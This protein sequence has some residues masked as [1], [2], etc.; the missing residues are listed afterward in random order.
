MAGLDGVGVSGGGK[1]QPAE[2][3][4]LLAATLPPSELGHAMWRRV[5][6]QAVR[7][8]SRWRSSRPPTVADL[9]GALHLPCLDD[10]ARRMREGRAG[11]LPIEP[12]ERFEVREMVTR[13]F[14]GL[15][16]EVCARA[17]RVLDGELHLFGQWRYHGRGEELSPG[18][19]ALDWA[20]DPI[21]GGRAPD[22]PSSA[23]N[24][25]QVGFDARAVWEAGRL[26]HLVW[27][28]QAWTLAGLPGTEHARGS[29]DRGLYA[30]ALALHVRDFL[31]TQPRGRGIHWTCAMEA[32]LRVM[33]L[34]WAVLLVRDSPELDALFWAEVQVA[35]WEHARFV[36][37]E[38]EDA[39]TVP[40]NHLL[41]DLAGLVTLGCLFPELPGAIDWRTRGLRAFGR[42]LLR[43]STSDGLS[44]ESSIPYHRFVVE[45]GLWVEAMARR[46]GLSLGAE[47]RERLW[48]M[49]WVLES[50]TLPDGRLP[51]LGDN[52]SSRAF[53]FEL[54]SPLDATFVASVRAG[55]GGGGPVPKVAP[56]AL[57]LGG[58]SG[59][60][61]AQ[62]C[63]DPKSAHEGPC[64]A[65][66]LAVLRQGRRGVTLWAGSN[67][68]RGLGGHA[69]NDKLS[70][71]VV[72]DGERIVVDPGCP[73]Y[74]QSPDER[75]RYRST[76]A[77]P[78]VR[79]DGEE[80]GPVPEGRT[81]LLPEHAHASLLEC[82][83]LRAEGEHVG[84]RRLDPP[85]L[86]RREVALPDGIDAV[87]ITDRILG[88]GSH[89]I[90]VR[91]PLAS[92]EVAPGEASVT[93]R[94]LLEKLE[95]L[96]FGEGRFD[97]HRIFRIGPEGAAG[98]FLAIACEQPWEARLEEST[99]S[100]GY[101]ERVCG[102]TVR[103]EI[104]APTP[105]AV[106]CAF[107]GQ[108]AGTRGLS[109][110]EE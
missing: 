35:L 30:R 3:Y 25:E 69:H 83:E 59:F 104:K 81:F 94:A 68:Q 67:G 73:V 8:L 21:H 63:V 75:D 95:T 103:V 89:V 52:D 7:R 80:Q 76:A 37:V 70:T 40:G 64:V 45:L 5:R 16:T 32:G 9:S 107:V 57:W 18:V 26:F 2:Y 22:L 29:S 101:G 84:Y 10:L 17:D 54:R 108:Q 55:L 4:R 43:Q 72:L 36:D 106:T 39:Q 13:H 74:L 62:A 33:N 61:R 97:P 90:E 96:P 92:R 41:S 1:L 56:E 44:F 14:P 12:Q 49:C 77:H 71:E 86:H 93:E 98:A 87:V 65:S 78:T 51:N 105:L 100:P 6:R 99:W 20:R 46:Q 82:S 24:P 34:A 88:E 60:R 66:G 110:G 109:W 31:A 85:A 15:A 19:T 28:A 47:V 53:A 11:R 38:M 102:R 91:W 79:L 27:L 42:E 58:V 50:A 48:R 23:I